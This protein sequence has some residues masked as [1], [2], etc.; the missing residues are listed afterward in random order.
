MIDVAFDLIDHDG[1]PVTPRSYRGRWLLVFFGFTHCRVV[2]PRNLAKLSTVLD[3]LGAAAG[4]ITPLYVS[5][6]PERDTPGRMKAWLGECYPRFTGL[7]GTKAAS[8]AARAGFRVF[9]ERRALP[10][11]EEGYDVPHSALTYLVDPDGR[12]RTH[13]SET[14]DDQT[15]AERIDQQIN[16][17]L[18]H[19]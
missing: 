4:A 16:P 17:E 6:D 10:D 7:T 14:L 12:Y 15:I 3:R 9:A 1:R 11:G 5:V 2:C 18:T 8:D 19:A 13:F